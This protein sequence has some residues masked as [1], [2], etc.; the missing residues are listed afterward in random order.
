RQ[1]VSSVALEREYVTGSKRIIRRPVERGAR[2]QVLD[3]GRSQAVASLELEIIEMMGAAGR[4]KVSEFAGARIGIIESA[5]VE[6]DRT[7]NWLDASIP[8]DFSVAFRR[9]VEIDVR[10]PDA[11]IEDAVGDID[12][13][14][15][16]RILKRLG[17]AAEDVVAGAADRDRPA[18]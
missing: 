8:I 12:G 15:R 10:T 14:L 18:E 7:P 9:I 4:V 13:A 2:G 5:E 1:R 6:R 16:R 17:D 3:P 11:S